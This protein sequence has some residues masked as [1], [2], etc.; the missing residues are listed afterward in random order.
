MLVLKELVNEFVTHGINSMRVTTTQQARII[1]HY[2]NTKE[3]F[4]VLLTVHLSIMLAVDQ[5]NAQ[6]LVL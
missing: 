3:N 6:I 2:K 5:L 1:H 4:D